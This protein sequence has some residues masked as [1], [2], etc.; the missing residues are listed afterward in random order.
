[1]DFK[2]EPHEGASLTEANIFLRDFLLQKI[3]GKMIHTKTH[4]NHLFRS[5]PQERKE[6]I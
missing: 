4:R 1:M 3:N 5:H 2:N 6:S